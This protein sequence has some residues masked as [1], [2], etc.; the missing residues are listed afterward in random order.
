MVTLRSFWGTEVYEYMHGFNG[1]RYPMAAGLLMCADQ[2]VYL[3]LHR[4]DRDFTDEDVA[5][6]QLLQQVVAPAYA[7]R[8]ALDAAIR[9]FDLTTAETAR[10]AA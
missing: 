10:R 8:A 5:D 1:G 2:V 7:Y 3:A 9:Q 6:L 4:S